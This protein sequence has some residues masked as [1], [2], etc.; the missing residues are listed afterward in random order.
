MADN[1]LTKLIEFFF[2]NNKHAWNSHCQTESGQLLRAKKHNDEMLWQ[3]S[4][5]G[6]TSQLG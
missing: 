1:N 6:G 4:I 5:P 3:C 2:S